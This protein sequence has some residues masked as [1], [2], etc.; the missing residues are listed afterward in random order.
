[1]KSDI[2]GKDKFKVRYVAKGYSQERGIDYGETF[3]PTA[4][5]TS[6]RV[7]LQ[8]AAVTVTP[9]NG[10]ENSIFTCSH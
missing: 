2:E 5:L 6:V 3:S 8:K 7:L 9:S 1:M 4:S 10:C